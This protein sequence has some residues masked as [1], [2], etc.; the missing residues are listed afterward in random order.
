MEKGKPRAF[1]KHSQSNSTKSVVEREIT[2]ASKSYEK[3]PKM[4]SKSSTN[5]K[6]KEAR[7]TTK[8]F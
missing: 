3:I 4:V 1:E 6:E 5:E 2:L 7:N 8:N